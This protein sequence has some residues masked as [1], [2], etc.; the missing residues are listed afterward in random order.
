MKIV[1]VLLL[2][3]VAAGAVGWRVMF[4]MP[5]ESFTG[6]LPP[7][8]PAATDLSEELRGHIDRLAGEIGDRNLQRYPQLIKAAG[9]TILCEGMIHA[10][11]LLLPKL[12]S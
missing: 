3:L 12:C 2:L 5:G 1:A 4:S 7:L 9:A 6:P 8:D 11:P 10:R